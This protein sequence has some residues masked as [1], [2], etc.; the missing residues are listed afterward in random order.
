MCKSSVKYFD[1]ANVPEQNVTCTSSSFGLLI[2]EMGSPKVKRK[3]ISSSRLGVVCNGF[4][5]DVGLRV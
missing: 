4:K 1:D 2:T 3:C 5:D